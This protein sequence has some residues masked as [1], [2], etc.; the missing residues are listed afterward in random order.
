MSLATTP[1]YS[2]PQIPRPTEL[3]T[4]PTPLSFATGVSSCNR[5]FIASSHGAECSVH[6]IRIPSS[7]DIA[8]FTPF[9]GTTLRRQG[10]K[11]SKDPRVT[12]R[13]GDSPRG[14]LE[15]LR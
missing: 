1:T 15:D 12:R 9:R 3:K 4:A 11:A 6:S 7:I 14:Q 8:D 13:V 2:G 10:W 5:S